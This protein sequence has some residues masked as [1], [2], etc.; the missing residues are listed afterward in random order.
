MVG[1]DDSTHGSSPRGERPRW[2]RLALVFCA[3]AVVYGAVAGPR[4]LEPSPHFH[5]VDLAHS[6]MSGRLDTDT[7]RRVRRGDPLPGDPAGF[8]EAVDRALARSDGGPGGWNDWA[9]HHRLRLKGRADAPESGEEVAGVWPWK[10]TRGP[11]R[12]VFHTLDGKRMRIDR[13]LDVARTCGPDGRSP[14]DERVYHVSFPPFPAVVVAPLAAIQGYRVN[15]VLLTVL[16]GGLNAVLHLLFLQQLVARGLIR[17]TNQEILWLVALC[18]FGSVVFFSSVR[19]EVWFTALVLGF[20]LHLGYAMAALDA[21]RPLLAG[22]LLA[23]G[24]ATRTPLLFASLFFF[25]QVMW[26]ASGG[27]LSWRDRVRKIALFAIPCVLVGGGLLL[28]N[29]LRFDAPT[30]FG[31]SYLADGTR[32]SIREHG[33]FHWRFLGRNLQAMWTNLPAFSDGASWVQINRHGL[34]MLVTS[35][36][37]VWM[38]TRLP[39]SRLGW[40]ALATML[41][42]LVPAAF[43]Q[44]TGWEQFGYRFSLDWM[45]W[46][47]CLLALAPRPFGWAWKSAVVLGVAV[48]LFGAITFGRFGQFYVG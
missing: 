2:Q 33:L 18:A 47:I 1:N 30:E 29:W 10:D 34:G 37:L 32:H 6:W 43:Y 20:S 35:P 9:S 7:P 16:L 28:L 12:T 11:R 8:Q 45:P 4:L 3:V 46:M 22:A 17:R 27:R 21:R 13:A 31:H 26:P 42:V 15:D 23:A 36:V 25:V 40:S 5:F 14:C 44:N 41:C 38:F 48:N 24:F 19:G 39:S